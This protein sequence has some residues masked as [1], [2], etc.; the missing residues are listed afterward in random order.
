MGYKI[1]NAIIMAA[2]MSS[3]FV[4]ISFEKPK[5][6]INIRG[7]ILI[8]RQI[9]QLQEK[10]IHDIMIVVGYKKEQF[11]YLKEKYGVQLIENED[12]HIRNN[13]S[14]IYAARSYLNNTYVCSADNYFTVNPFEPEVNG[15]YYAA[16]FSRGKTNEWCL[17]TDHDDLITGV[18]IGGEGAWY[19]M[20]HTFWDRAF[21][22]R[23]VQI[24]ETVYQKE[25]IK[26]KLWEDIYRENLG[27]LHMKIRR[28]QPGQIYEFDTLDELR[29]F[30]SRYL[31]DSGSQV[32]RYLAKKLNCKE[33]EMCHLK[34][35]KSENGDVTGVRFLC[36]KKAYEFDFKSGILNNDA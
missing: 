18:R 33:S 17:Q 21:S 13:H 6:L 23:F 34:P 4:P 1:D 25:D 12:Y 7:E 11:E 30:D 16:L 14:S 28:Y 27:T 3:R 32:M 15:S 2:G 20:G 24:L 10:G 31:E 9:R 22:N 36:R 35:V 29:T 19:M 26:S 5:A 8:E